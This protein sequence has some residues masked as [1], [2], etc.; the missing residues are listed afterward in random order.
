MEIKTLKSVVL[1]NKQRGLVALLFVSLLSLTLVPG[2]AQLRNQKR[3]I[4][5]QLGDAAEGSRVTIASDAALSDYE[6]FRRGDRFYVK[7]A[8][9]DFTSLPQLRA[10]GFEDVQVQRVGD[11]ILVS[12]KLQPG[13]TARVE[14]N[15][16]RLHVIFSS[17]NRVARNRT[18]NAGANRVTPGGSRSARDRAADAA[19]PMPAGSE[20]AFRQR[21]ATE[22]SPDANEG[23]APR[24]TRAKITPRGNS[25][26]EVRKSESNRSDSAN[27]AVKTPSPF[28]SPTAVLTP[29]TSASYPPIAT[30]SPASSVNAEPA[31]TAAGSGNSESRS[32]ALRKWIAANRVATLLG[33]LILL[34]LILYF[35][36]AASRRRKTVTAAKRASVAKVQ[37]NTPPPDFD[38]LEDHS[39]VTASAADNPTSSY[40][41]REFSRERATVGATSAAALPKQAGV[42]TRPATTSPTVLHDQPGGEAEEREVFEL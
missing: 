8:L 34:N 10:D 5:L 40:A 27:A 23:R 42:L 4:S 29:S 35:A 24:T 20:L 33:A 19:G 38:D 41:S 18:V 21:V 26:T 15:S 13:A 39:E 14:Q 31:S 36:M 2:A 11:G 25:V 7:I 3:F 32:H 16:N 37:P 17:P 22:R 9:G 1:A 12:F 28:P 30:V 6:A